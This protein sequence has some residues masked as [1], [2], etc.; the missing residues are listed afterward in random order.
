MGLIS[1]WSLVRMFL[2]FR[3]LGVSLSA[4]YELLCGIIV[5]AKLVPLTRIPLTL[6]SFPIPNII[7]F[8]FPKSSFSHFTP[9]SFHFYFLNFCFEFQFREERCNRRYL[10]WLGSFV[11]LYNMF[12]NWIL[13]KHQDWK[14]FT[15]HL[16]YVR[17]FF[18]F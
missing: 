14:R 11:S 6:P 18:F 17:I 13:F 7:I 10:S 3:V 15:L 1:F 12:S 9:F 8:F 16:T 5:S 4:F 2:S